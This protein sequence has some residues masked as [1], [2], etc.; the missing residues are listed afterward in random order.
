ME[1]HAEEI[2]LGEL[3]Q[4]MIMD[5]DELEDWMQE[6]I[7]PDQVQIPQLQ[8]DEIGDL[9]YWHADDQFYSAIELEQMGQWLINKK[10]EE[11]RPDDFDLDDIDDLNPDQ[12]FAFKIIVE[13]VQRKQQL[14]MRIEGFAGSQYFLFNVFCRISCVSIL[15]LLLVKTCVSDY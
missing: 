14:L 2:D 5:E 4:E 11:Q 9:D 10:R 13:H 12:N 1:T 3:D 6:Q 7:P 15:A 8:V